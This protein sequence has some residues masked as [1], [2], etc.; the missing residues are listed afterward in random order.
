MPEGWEKLSAVEILRHEDGSEHYNGIVELGVGGKI[1]ERKVVVNPHE[2]W[3]DNPHE[4]QSQGAIADINGTD[5][6]VNVIGAMTSQEG[7]RYYKVEGSETA[8]PESKIT[9]VDGKT[10]DKLKPDTDSQ[11]I[12][13][14]LQEGKQ[15][16]EEQVRILRNEKSGLE[17]RLGELSN[18]FDSLKAE[19]DQIK[20]KLENNEEMEEVAGFKK[21]DAVAVLVE[22][23]P[24]E[25]EMYEPGY[26]VVDFEGE[27]GDKKIVIEDKKSHERSPVVPEWLVHEGDLDEPEEP[28]LRTR[29]G[30]GWNRT[31]G[32]IGG[33]ILG[34]QAA[35][36]NGKY[37]LLDRHG[38]VIE[39]DVEV[40]DGYTP[41]S[42]RAGAMA[43]GGAALVGAGVLVGYLIWG[44]H[45]GPNV[46]NH[47][48]TTTV[49]RGNGPTGNTSIFGIPGPN[50]SGRHVDFFNSGPGHRFTGVDLPKRLHLRK[51]FGHGVLVDDHGRTIVG[52]LKDGLFDRQGNL[53]ERA[54]T[55][56]RAKGYLLT[57]GNLA[58]RYMTYIW[59]R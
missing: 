6:P 3:L 1:I 13:Q 31:T 36:H 32:R 38:R 27:E 50:S 17:Q 23:G 42:E 29:F 53:S 45:G 33:F 47:H 25:D 21:G 15:L 52:R 10:K 40:I 49:P 41:E 11:E 22:D 8:I 4:N 58:S 19:L 20:K 46:I 54:K 57:Q 51:V 28:T 2:I 9:W 24:A 55:I 56:S 39:E 35:L 12:I 48:H 16:L 37:N 34:R 44:R 18:Q 5:H 7:E 30:R 43:I 14:R 26:E 59:T